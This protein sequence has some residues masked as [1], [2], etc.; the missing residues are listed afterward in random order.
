VVDVDEE[1]VSAADE[2]NGTYIMMLPRSEEF[3]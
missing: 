2:D 1:V 3:F